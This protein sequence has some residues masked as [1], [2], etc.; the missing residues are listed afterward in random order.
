MYIQPNRQL[1]AGVYRLKQDEKKYYYLE[2][3]SDCFEIEGKNYGD[4]IEQRDI[5]WERYS[6][7]LGSMGAMFTGGK[8]MGKSRLAEL[9]SNLAISY[10]IPVVLVTEINA[11]IVTVQYIAMISNVVIFYDEFGK[12]FNRPLQDKML[13]MLSGVASGKKLFLITENNTNMLSELIVDRPGR[14]L[15][16]YEYDRLDE[17]VIQ[18]YC[19][20][21]AVS[22]YIY[23]NIID[24]WKQTPGFSND[25]LKAL[26]EEHEFRPQDTFEMLLKRLNVS[27]LTKPKMLDIEEV[28]TYVDDP[29]SDIKIKKVVKYNY[30]EDVTMKDFNNNRALWMRLIDEATHGIRIDKNSVINI[31]DKII[32]C[33]VGEYY[34]VLKQ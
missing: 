18:Q 33:K 16:H 7:M 5:V 20:D 11:D 4:V 28:Y 24:K 30:S 17:L 19:A 32:T 14:V 29:K 21:H 22:Q 3:V 31:E 6:K 26:V 9:I 15:Y 1:P 27:S 12:N 23:D 2:R 10:G 13:T 25:H 8:G 34:V